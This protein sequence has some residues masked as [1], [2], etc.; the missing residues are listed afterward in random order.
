MGSVGGSVLRGGA[1]SDGRRLVAAPVLEMGGGR[2]ARC[3][4]TWG[5]WRYVVRL[6]ARLVGN[7]KSKSSPFF[8]LVHFG[9]FFL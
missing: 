2:L 6:N 3:N 7:S 1:L 9:R 5:K 4:G 8:F